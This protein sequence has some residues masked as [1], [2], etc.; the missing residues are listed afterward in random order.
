MKT[1]PGCH[2][3]FNPAG[4]QEWLPFCSERCRLVDLGAWLNEEHRIASETVDTLPDAT[5]TDITT[6]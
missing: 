3:P 1:C 4:A 2:K 5:E 6:H